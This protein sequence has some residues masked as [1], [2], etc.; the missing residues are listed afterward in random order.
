MSTDGNEHATAIVS[1]NLLCQAINMH[2][3]NANCANN[4]KLV[5][6]AALD[7][8]NG[9]VVS[10][11]SRSDLLNLDVTKLSHEGALPGFIPLYEGMPV[12]L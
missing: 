4:N 6:C 2:K 9:E 11:P 8:A 5:L 12:I 10:L 7:T 3:A 1:T